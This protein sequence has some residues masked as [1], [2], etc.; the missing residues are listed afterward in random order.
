MTPPLSGSNTPT[1]TSPPSQIQSPPIGPSQVIPPNRTGPLRKKTVSKADISEP[2]LV[3]YTSN[4]DTI[5]LPEGASLKNGMDDVGPPPPVPPINP[6][7]K[8]V[9]RMFSIGRKNHTASAEDVRSPPEHSPSVNFNRS[10]TPDP[11]Q[12]RAPEPDFP[13]DAARGNASVNANAAGRVRST[14]RPP[15]P[16]QALSSPPMRQDYGFGH[17]SNGSPERVQR[18]P[19]PPLVEGGMF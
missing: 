8:A 10:K 17:P 7:R 15:P 2:T 12:S 13:F 1:F 14:S 18:S 19:A 6:R 3:S 4:I 16:Q 9:N 11:W 5:D